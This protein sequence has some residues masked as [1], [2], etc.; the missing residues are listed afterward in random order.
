MSFIKTAYTIAALA[1]LFL[2]PSAASTNFALM[3]LLINSLIK[4]DK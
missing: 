4:E 3:I 2:Y 1:G